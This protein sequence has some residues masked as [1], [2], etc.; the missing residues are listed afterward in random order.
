[1]NEF[2]NEEI[3][4]IESKDKLRRLQT[5]LGG[6]VRLVGSQKLVKFQHHIREGALTKVH[7]KGRRCAPCHLALLTE[8]LVYSRP[9]D[10]RCAPSHLPTQDCRCWTKHPEPKGHPPR[11]IH[12]R[13]LL[14]DWGT[15][16]RLC[17]RFVSSIS[18]PQSLPCVVVV[19]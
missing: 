10:N 12:R 3:R 1:M 11:T 13:R 2:N 8:E 14:T 4:V 15:F 9:K 19:A 5:R 7:G 17:R 18:S 16:L 6:R